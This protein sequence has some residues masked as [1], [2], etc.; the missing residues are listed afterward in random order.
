MVIQVING[1]LATVFDLALG[2]SYTKKKK[3]RIDLHHLWMLSGWCY[4]E[5]DLCYISL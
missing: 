3:V 5:C 2:I 1:V 4:A